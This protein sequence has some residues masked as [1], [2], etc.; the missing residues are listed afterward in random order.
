MQ[1]LITALSDVLALMRHHLP[2]DRLPDPSVLAAIFALAG[3]VLCFWGARLLRA[4]F[5][6]GFLAGGISLGIRVARTIPVDDLVGL[7]VGGAIAAIIG[8]L[9]YRWWVGLLTGLCAVV[10]V[11]LIGGPRVLPQV[12]KDFQDQ[13]Y[14]S[15]G[16]VYVLADPSSA[17]E[18]P[19]MEESEYYWIQVK[20][21][22]WNQQRPF[23]TRIGLALALAGVLGVIVGVMLTRT[24]AIV[25]TSLFGVL[26]VGLAGG[27][28]ISMQWPALWTQMQ[29]QPGWLLGGL[30]LLLIISLSMQARGGRP[31]QMAAMGPAHPNQ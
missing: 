16:A 19:A 21:Y 14:G 26:A 17:G 2:W 3:V 24:A 7:V 23:T 13:H 29:A 12:I 5:V 20:D 30:G 18:G 11:L 31:V 8:H 1:E 15:E 28:L 25:G 6:L 9:L 22:F 10:L 4:L 27:S